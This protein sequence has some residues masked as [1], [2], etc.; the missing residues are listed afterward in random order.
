MRISSLLRAKL[1]ALLLTA[2]LFATASAQT[3]TS[4]HIFQN[5]GTITYPAGPAVQGRDGNLY[6]FTDFTSPGSVFR[7]QTNGRVSSVY[8]FTSNDGGD[9][10][11]SPLLLGGDGNWYGTT[12]NN[13]SSGGILYRIT[14]GGTFTILHTFGSADGD[15][16]IGSPIEANGELYGTTVG[17]SDVGPSVYTYNM[18]G[19]FSVLYQ[20]NS[21]QLAYSGGA[22]V[23]VSDG[24][25]YGVGTG[26]DNCGA[27][28]KMTPS[29]TLLNVYNFDCN[30]SIGDV[31]SPLAVGSDG[32]FYGTGTGTLPF[33]VGTV[34]KMDQSGVATLLHTFGGLDDGATPR[35]G[36]ALG[37][38]GNLY[39]T[40]DDGGVNVYYG[41]IYQI[42]STGSYQQLH[43]FG[44]S[45][46]NPSG[47]VQH[48]DGKFYGFVSFGNNNSGVFYDLDMGLGPFI[49]FVL[50]KGRVGQTAQILSQGL[51]GTTSVTFN[52]VPATSFDV[53][54]ETFM[55]AVVPSGATTGP[56]AVTT[57]GGAL[58]SNVSFRIIQ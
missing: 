54:S 43:S 20:F 47:L 45:G 53:V 31:N 41:T 1:S 49:T 34:F 29:G 27:A 50:P 51:T 38:D 26:S 46:W 24:N 11:V 28:F 4:L 15:A 21:S 56:V 55:T 37:T 40:T 58:T 2:I 7:E 39:G 17:G 30:L 36:L 5:Y 12:G 22:V 8:V 52:G 33:P 6:S 3:I 57:P 14:R 35:G 10:P 18:S 25:L 32:N 19:T 44:S 9:P 42:S 16:P 13:S 48:T 23:Q